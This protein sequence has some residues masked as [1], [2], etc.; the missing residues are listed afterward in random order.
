MGNR[1]GMRR[2]IYEFLLSIGLVKEEKSKLS[3]LKQ[4]KTTEPV[5]RP[6][7]EDWANEFKFGS[8]DRFK[9]KS[10]ISSVQVKN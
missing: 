10:D 9:D 1:K 7:F 6:S 5:E 4:F 8:A 2:R 3:A